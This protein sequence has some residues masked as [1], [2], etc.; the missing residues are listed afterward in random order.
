[1]MYTIHNYFQLLDISSCIGVNK[2]EYSVY[3]ENKVILLFKS[4]INR[5]TTTYIISLYYYKF[6]LY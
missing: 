4:Y 5:L 1:M 2:C 3:K 6:L